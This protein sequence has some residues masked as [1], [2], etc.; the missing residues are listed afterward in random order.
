VHILL[1]KLSVHILMYLQPT[2]NPL[3]VGAYEVQ[4]IVV[5]EAACHRLLFLLMKKVIMMV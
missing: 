1:F 3:S 2:I 4:W 5:M